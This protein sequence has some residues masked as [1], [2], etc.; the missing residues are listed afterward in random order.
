M[1]RRATTGGKVGKAR[2][3]KT[4]GRRA[5]R[6]VARRGSSDAN[7]RE[8]LDQARRERD[9]RRWSSRP[10]PPRCS[11][12]SPARPAT[13]SRCSRRCWRTRPA[14]ARPSSASCVLCEGDGYRVV[15]QHGAPARV[16]RARRAQPLRPRSGHRCL[17]DDR[18]RPS[19]SSILPISPTRRE[20][21]HA[22]AGTVVR[23][24]P[25]LLMVPM[26]KDDELIGAIVIYRQEVR[27]FT[28][29]QIELVRT[30]PPR[31]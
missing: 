10:R 2:R 14:S 5:A 8:Q 13:C 3:R 29:K 16:C 7:L 17:D 27:P 1:K 11:R 12:S 15:A 28:D 6:V 18:C 20:F 4:Q 24:S 25:D 23:A 22:A 9:P 31:R 19:S 21:R 26:L 30:S